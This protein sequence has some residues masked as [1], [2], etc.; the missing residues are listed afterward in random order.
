MEQL[1]LRKA[2]GSYVA[3]DIKNNSSSIL[4]HNEGY[5]FLKT[6]CGSPS[7]FES[8]RKNLFAMLRFHG[9][10]TWFF[11]LSAAEAHWPDLIK[12]LKKV[13]DNEEYSDEQI[14][15]MPPDEIKNLILRDPVTCARH[16]QYRTEILFSQYLKAKEAPLGELKNFFYRV[17]FQKRGSPYL[18]CLL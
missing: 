10:P 15:T 12:N 18:H 13:L 14:Q 3:G 1:I 6:I 7:Y 4:C 17:E 16:F 2:T 9:T 8:V 5:R 11:T